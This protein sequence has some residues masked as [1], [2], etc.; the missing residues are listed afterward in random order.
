[1]QHE[2]VHRGEMDVV[3]ELFRHSFDAVL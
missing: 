2:A 3:R 1:M